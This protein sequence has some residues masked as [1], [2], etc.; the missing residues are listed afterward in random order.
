MQSMAISRNPNLCSSNFLFSIMPNV[1]ATYVSLHSF[2]HH[3]T[4]QRLHVWELHGFRGLC[5]NLEGVNWKLVCLP[6]NV[7]DCIDD[8]EII[9]AL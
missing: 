2:F 7:D 6:H 3:V 4:K 9:M 5:I 1:T 8:I